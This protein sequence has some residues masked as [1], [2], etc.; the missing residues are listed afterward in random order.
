MSPA[1]PVRG[2]RLARWAATCVLAAALAGCG[3]PG[4]LIPEQQ[5]AAGRG[6]APLPAPT[7]YRVEQGDTL[8]SIA[9]R[10]G[11][12]WRRVAAWNAIGAPYTIHV[13]D[14]IRLRPSPEMRSAVA[15]TGR[16]SGTA[17]GSERAPASR[18]ESAPE[19]REEREPAAN[20]PTDPE[21][22]PAPQPGPA[23]AGVAEIPKASTR[24]VAGVHWRWPADGRVS[25]PYDDSAAR[26][27]ILIAGDEGQDVRAAADGE[28]VYS[29]DGLI[30]YGQLII[31]KHSDSMLSAYAHNRDRL[32][33]EGDRVRAGQRIG[34]MGRNERD[35]AVLHFEVRRDGKPENPADYLPGR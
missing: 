14:A 11:L 12:D 31:I 5:H 20:P 34:R 7:V 17:G 16:R 1:P 2:L 30:G 8:Y 22:A 26:K 6:A 32:V 9:F 25:R 3:A 10:Y 24:L 15:G 23:T 21:P 28:V 33:R 4:P 13:G 35:A 19:P 27:G 18:P 29:G